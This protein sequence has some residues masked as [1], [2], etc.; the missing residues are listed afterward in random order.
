[1]VDVHR[2]DQARTNANIATAM[3]VTGGAAIVTGV[4][5]VFT[6]PSSPR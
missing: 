2:A 3:F 4:I 5:L 6:A 1:M